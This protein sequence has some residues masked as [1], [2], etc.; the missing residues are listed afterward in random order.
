MK[1]RIVISIKTLFSLEIH[2]TK[3]QCQRQSLLIF[4]IKKDYFYLYLAA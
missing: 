2:G 4:C 3:T 1:N